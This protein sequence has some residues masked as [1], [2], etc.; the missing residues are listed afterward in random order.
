[1]RD[2][3]VTGI[4]LVLREHFPV[5]S[6]HVPEHASGDLESTCWRPINHVVEG[7]K[8][9]AEI[10]VKSNALA[11]QAAKDEPAI[12]LHGAGAR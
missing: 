5:A 7:G 3:R 4:G 2:H 1:M 10:V 9:F 8:G 12:D 6:M 11:A